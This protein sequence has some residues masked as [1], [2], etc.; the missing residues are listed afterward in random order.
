MKASKTIADP[1][2]PGK[3]GRGKGKRRGPGRPVQETE[4]RARLLDAARALFAAK[5]FD[6]TSTREIA[7][8][9]GANIGLISYY[10]GGKEELYLA[11]LEQS[12]LQLKSHAVFSAS[13]EGMDRCAFRELLRGVIA[14]HIASLQAEPELML[15][16]QRELLDGAPR[17]LALI[18][19]QLQL[20]LDQLV[21]LLR[22]GKRL[23]YVRPELHEVTFLMVLSR[24]ITGYFFLH[25]QLAE[26]A[27]P[28]AQM[29]APETTAALEQLCLTFFDG[30]LR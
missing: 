27:A 18:N 24:A 10:F 15:I 14:L 30:A 13:L 6:K 16:V 12:A 29:L 2:R 22:E 5:G 3:T 8:S 21:A 23:G 19:G 25:W 28:V 20:L 1:V 9:V 17:S 7:S 11:V 4:L 26:K